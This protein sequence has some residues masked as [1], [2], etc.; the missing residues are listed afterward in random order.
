VVLEN[1]L[2]MK[3]LCTQVQAKMVTAWCNLPWSL[4]AAFAALLLSTST[5]PGARS[6]NL[7]QDE[8]AT[9]FGPELLRSMHCFKEEDT[10]TVAN[11]EWSSSHG[12]TVR[13]VP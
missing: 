11:T 13:G 12:F 9:E 7:L 10:V 1:I 8:V 3:D 2:C 5:V 4:S 6:K